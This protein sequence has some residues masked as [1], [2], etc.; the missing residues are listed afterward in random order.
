MSSVFRDWRDDG[1]HVADEVHVAVV[2]E[3]LCW[4]MAGQPSCIE[5][6]CAGRE[7]PTETTHGWAVRHQI[8]IMY[9]THKF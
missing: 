8:E 3:E 4:L 9:W 5:D 2:V 1:C 7:I 6:S